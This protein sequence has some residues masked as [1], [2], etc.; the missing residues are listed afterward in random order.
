M[1]VRLEQSGAGGWTTVKTAKTNAGGQS[2]FSLTAASAPT[3]VRLVAI[4]PD[5]TVAAESAP[6]T[7]P[8]YYAVTLTGARAG[9]VRTGDARAVTVSGRT[10]ALQGAELRLE[11]RPLDALGKPVSATWQRD[12]TSPYSTLDAAK[13]TFA[14]TRTMEAAGAYEVRVVRYASASTVQVESAAKKVKVA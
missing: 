7:M 11:W 9:T 1:P 13:G 3:T 4:G 14:L 2:S 5:G 8:V 12:T 10:A 6:V